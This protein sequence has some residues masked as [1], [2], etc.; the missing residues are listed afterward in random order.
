MSVTTEVAPE[1][2][3]LRSLPVP[4]S[5]PHDVRTVR[6]QHDDVPATQGSLALAFTSAAGEDDE[7][8]PEF[9]PQPT[10]SRDLPEPGAA[11]TALVRA[12]VEVLGGT[13]PSSQ[14]ARWLTTD[15][16]AALQRR[17][18]LAARLRRGAAPSARQAVVRRVRVC[19]PRDGVVE[20]CAVV[21]DGGRVRAVA[22]RLE[23]LDGRWRATAVEVG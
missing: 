18:G 8:D 22:L 17:A 3:A 16:Y 11:C 14:L 6:R 21:I 15:V 1:L 20:A 10:S 23:G 12:V 9:G 7:P 4:V 2:R 19:E 13:R 5:E